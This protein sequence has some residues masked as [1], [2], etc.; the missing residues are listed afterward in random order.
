L[1][2]STNAAAI[3]DDSGSNL[4]AA[5]SIGAVADTIAEVDVLAETSVVIGIAVEFRILV[6]HVGKACR[7][8]E[9]S[10]LLRASWIGHALYGCHW[11][12]G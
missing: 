3:G 7:L 9:E 12:L 10:Q 6:E 11:T 2:T 5:N 4:R 8:D 1:L